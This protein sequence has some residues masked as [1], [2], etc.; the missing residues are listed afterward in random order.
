[1]AH[2]LKK[3]LSLSDLT[4]LA[5]SDLLEDPPVFYGFRAINVEDRWLAFFLDVSKAQ[6]SY[7]VN[8]KRR[9]PPHILLVMTHLLAILLQKV[10]AE[11]EKADL[12]ADE[13][14]VIDTYLRNAAEWLDLQ[15][16]ANTRNLGSDR[17]K[18]LKKAHHYWK[19]HVAREK[20][21]PMELVENRGHTIKVRTSDFIPVEFDSAEVFEETA[22]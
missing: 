14:R 6:V 11:Y 7:W 19:V 20:P 4:G 8:R 9:I 18:L 10:H 21:I 2:R 15:V 22:A 16:A 12:S 3:R 17:E 13:R 5:L 1:M